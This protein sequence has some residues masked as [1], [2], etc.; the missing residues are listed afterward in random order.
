MR[1]TDKQSKLLDLLT[2]GQFHSG[3]LLAQQLAM[4]RAGVCKQL[5]QLA[6]LLDLNLIATSGKGYCLAPPLELLS[7]AK[8]NAALNAQSHTLI[9]QIDIHAQIDSTNRYLLEQSRSQNTTGWVCLAE[10]QTAGKGRRGREWVSP[11]GHNIYL[12]LAWQFPQGG[13]A[14]LSGLSLAIG[15]AVIRA[16]QAQGI[17]GLGLKWPNDIYALGKKLGGILIEVSGETDGSCHAVI[18]VGLNLFLPAH[19]ANSI[20]QAWTD[21]KQLTGHSPARNQLVAELL[22]QL[23]SVVAD[24]ETR[25][26]QYYVDEW[27]DYDCLNGSLATLFIGQQRVVGTVVGVDDNGLL[28]IEKQDGTIQAFAS[29]EVSFNA[30][31]G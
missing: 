19:K 26:I 10:Q 22:Q 23:L 1:L 18:G 24:F 4:S 11:F 20:N 8:I 25:G 7:L 6:Q 15:V 5:T 27:R 13:V 9:Q 17:D 28:L 3:T 12:S 16:L 14:A 30:V 21:I 31:S 2:D 29:G